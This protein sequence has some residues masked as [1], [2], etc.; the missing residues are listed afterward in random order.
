MLHHPVPVLGDAG[1]TAEGA[2]VVSAAH[3]A[4][5]VQVL[6]TQFIELDAHGAR[7]VGGI[8]V[9]PPHRGGFQDVAV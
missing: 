3:L 2:A 4:V 5:D 7:A 6:E 8:N 9:V 1:D